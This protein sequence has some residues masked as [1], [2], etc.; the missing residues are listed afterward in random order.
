MLSSW[1]ALSTDIADGARRAFEARAE[2]LAMRVDPAPG[3]PYGRRSL[4][5][6]ELGE[7]MLA[8]WGEAECAPHDHAAGEGMVHVLAG[9]FTETEWV[10]REGLLQRGAVRRWGA[11]DSIPVVAGTIHSMIAHDAG[12]TLHLYRP[13]ISGMRVFDPVRQETLSVRDDCGAWIPRDEGMIVSRLR[14][15][16]GRAGG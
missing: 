10:W 8:G 7:V 3:E 6:D 14:W 13:P 15:R 16:A 1:K 12:T 4:H 5:R 9:S 11:G 2:L